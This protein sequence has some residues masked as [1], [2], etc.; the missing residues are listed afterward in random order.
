MRRQPRAI[1]LAPWEVP[2][3]DP[4]EP[5]PQ[6]PEVTAKRMTSRIPIALVI[7]T[8][9]S[10]ILAVLEATAPHVLVHTLQAAGGITV[11]YLWGV[12]GGIV[13]EFLA[14]AVFVAVNAAVYS[15]NALVVFR[16]L[17]LLA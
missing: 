8:F 5:R 17:E 9:T 10:I 11:M 1:K 4:S 15:L 3:R 14:E 2:R 6:Q 13:P 12:H 16:L 7:G